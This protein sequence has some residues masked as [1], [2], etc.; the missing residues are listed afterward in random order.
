MI[1]QFDD[2]SFHYG[3]TPVL[4]NVTTS[5]E[6][7]RFICLL[8]A[9]GA[10]KTTLLR[11][12]TGE[13]VPTEGRVSL[14]GSRGSPVLSDIYEHVAVIPQNVQD[15]PYITA[16]DLVE[17]GRFHPRRRLG[18]RLSSKDKNIVDSSL[19]LCD[20][21]HLADRPLTEISGGEKQRTWLAFCLAQ[22]KDLL[23]LDESLQGVDYFSKQ[24][25]FR[26][27][28]DVATR[29][30]GVVLTTHDLDLAARFAD[31]VLVLRDGML[32]HDGPPT[33]DLPPLLVDRRAA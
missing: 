30:K 27:L 33:V 26:M 16:R 12:I 11:L 6:S 19:D 20:L 10:G 1:V 31:H 3:V 7:G 24:F 28:K 18:W 13:V 32:V 22:E 23:V 25:F 15:P 17:L 8:G 21:K 2:V 4:R 5:I 9:N 29:G 14:V